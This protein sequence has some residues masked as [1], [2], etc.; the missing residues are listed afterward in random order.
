MAVGPAPLGAP[1]PQGP[2][3][4][5]CN[6]DRI[7][8][9]KNAQGPYTIKLVLQI[10]QNGIV[11]TATAEGAPTPDIKSRIERQAQEWIFE[12]YL[13]DGVAVNVKLNTNVQVNIIKPR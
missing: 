9:D 7:L 2:Q 6:L 12:P 1:V 3:C 4:I 5:V 8:I 13:K 11:K 10:A